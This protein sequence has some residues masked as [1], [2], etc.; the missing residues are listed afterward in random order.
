MQSIKAIPSQPPHP[1]IMAD[2]SNKVKNNSILVFF[3]KCRLCGAPGTSLSITFSRNIERT[4]THTAARWVG[5]T[6]CSDTQ[7][8]S[9]ILS[10]S[11]TIHKT[12]PKLNSG[13]RT[14]LCWAREC[15]SYPGIQQRLK[16]TQANNAED[17]GE[18]DQSWPL[19]TFQGTLTREPSHTPANSDSWTF[20]LIIRYW[21]NEHDPCESA[22]VL[23]RQ[24]VR[25]F[26]MS[27][28]S[29]E[30][31]PQ[32][33][34]Q[35]PTQLSQDPVNQQYRMNFTACVKITSDLEDLRPS[36]CV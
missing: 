35:S 12:T 36:A 2:G 34:D 11:R 14:E 26:P 7:T 30:A 1:S 20:N 23:D 15:S 29:C 25:T 5:A 22:R 8:R 18:Q 13:H 31:P 24:P 32:G 27:L 6:L 17:G 4:Q 19:E 28:S 21:E 9:Q 10:H 3:R 33:Q 16:S